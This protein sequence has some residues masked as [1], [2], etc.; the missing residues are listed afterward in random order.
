MRPGLRVFETM[1]AGHGRLL[2]GFAGFEGGVAFVDLVPVDDVPP[3]GEIFGTA[4]VVFQVVGVL[5]DVVAEDGVEALGDGAVL[6][7]SADDLHFT[8]GLAGEPDASAAE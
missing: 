6:I 1:L 3:G 4:V 5:P 7:G 8:G 2:D